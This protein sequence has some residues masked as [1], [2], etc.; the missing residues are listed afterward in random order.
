MGSILNSANL[1]GLLGIFLIGFFI[2]I[3]AEIM[4]RYSGLS[5]INFIIYFLFPLLL[6]PIIYLILMRSM[7]LEHV[8]SV[9]KNMFTELSTKINGS[10]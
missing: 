4:V 1:Y 10:K 9:K 3:F 6:M 8:G 2:L 5:N 7:K